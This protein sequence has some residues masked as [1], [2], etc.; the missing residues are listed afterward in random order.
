MIV[1]VAEWAVFVGIVGW[2]LTLAML[3]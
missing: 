3:L 2:F 1:A